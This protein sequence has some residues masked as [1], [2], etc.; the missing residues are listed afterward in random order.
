MR[1]VV[2]TSQR[3]S[4]T[5]F[6]ALDGVNNGERQASRLPAALWRAAAASGNLDVF[7]FSFSPW[8]SAKCTK[9]I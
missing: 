6:F 5:S 7:K 3:A 2:V 8:N 9:H 1:M 4:A